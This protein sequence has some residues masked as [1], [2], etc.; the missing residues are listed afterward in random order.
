[1]LPEQVFTLDA[2]P[3]RTPQDY[4]K[5]VLPRVV[6]YIP[7]AMSIDLI[8]QV[9]R[10]VRI[11]ACSIRVDLEVLLHNALERSGILYH[12]SQRYQDALWQAHMSDTLGT[13]HFPARLCYYEGVPCENNN[14]LR[15]CMVSQMARAIGA[16]VKLTLEVPGML[17]MCE[18]L[19]GSWGY[20]ERSNRMER[21]VTLYDQFMNIIAA[22]AH[23]GTLA[24]RA[25]RSVFVFQ[26]TWCATK[27]RVA[28]SASIRNQPLRIFQRTW[29]SKTPDLYIIGPGEYCGLRRGDNGP[30]GECIDILGEGTYAVVA[31]YQR[32][33]DHKQVA[34]KFQAIPIEERNQPPPP[35]RRPAYADLAC[36]APYDD[37]C[38]HAALTLYAP[39]WDGEPHPVTGD[40]RASNFVRLIDNCRAMINLADQ[41]NEQFR[42]KMRL[43]VDS[44]LESLWQ[45][46]VQEYAHGEV[47]DE[48]LRDVCQY[49]FAAFR[50]SFAQ[51]AGSLLALGRSRRFTHNDLTT[52]NV[53]MTPLGPE[54]D[55]IRYLHYPHAEIWVPLVDSGR[56]IAKILDF[57][58]SR[59]EC[60]VVGTVCHSTKDM[61]SISQYC[62]AIDLQTLM[63]RTLCYSIATSLR[64]AGSTDPASR[65]FRQSVKMLDSRVFR[66]LLDCMREDYKEG[67]VPLD[68]RDIIEY[69]VLEQ[70]HKLPIKYNET[71]RLANVRLCHDQNELRNTI[72]TLITRFESAEIRQGLLDVPPPDE[73]TQLIDLGSSIFARSF[74]A[75]GMVKPAH[76]E[77]HDLFLR[78]AHFDPYRLKPSDATRENTWVMGVEWK[79]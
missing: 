78:R 41:V 39:R 52:A 42:T 58:L 77:A 3:Q 61:P 60:P 72:T 15:P 20:I 53:I 73:F 17:E 47:L 14:H 65:H 71:R 18:F 2:L 19:L 28:A 37:L 43:H 26:S 44:A 4:V 69:T 76:Q 56:R 22:Y 5:A 66:M 68:P 46:T 59:I 64:A 25:W 54:H 34:V 24:E 27:D 55:H 67:S 16:L 57:S 63:I 30:Y 36:S 23:Q 50:S 11:S 40:M 38:V 62:P 1:M 13:T 45:V 7:R 33:S 70:S 51:V 35:N 6:S 74:V 12:I 79:D 49:D 32:S 8:R 31:L 29:G 75:W 48:F 21:I 9:E 10:I